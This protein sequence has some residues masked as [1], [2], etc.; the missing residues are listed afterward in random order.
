MT[1]TKAAMSKAVDYFAEQIA[2][3]MCG[4]V[5][6]A[7]IDTVRVPYHGELTPIKYLAHTSADGPRIVVHPYDQTARRVIVTALLEAGYAAYLGSNTQVL[8]NTPPIGSQERDRVLKRVATLAEDAR[9]AVRNVRKR[10]RKGD[11]DEKALQ[12]AT[13]DHVE[14]INTLAKERSDFIRR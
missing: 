6:P 12:S 14:R 5:T 1:E 10:A 8:V 2:G 4:A 3:I 11:F 9:V 13:D 7:L